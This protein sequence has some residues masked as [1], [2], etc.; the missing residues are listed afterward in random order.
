MEGKIGRKWFEESYRR[1]LVDM[2]IPD[3]D[4]RFL[5]EFDPQRYVEMLTLANVTSAMVYANSH[6]GNCYWPTK[7]GHMHKGLKGRDILGEIIDLCHQRNMDVI[8]Y[9]SLI[10]NNWAYQNHSDWR[11]I[12]IDGREAG[13]NSRYGVC[14]PNSPY[15]DFALAQIEELCKSYEFEGIFFDMTFWPAVC[16]CPH[17]RKRYALEVGGE[18][19][20][21]IDWEDPKWVKFQRKRE[22]W[23]TEFASLATSTV[24]RIRPE[25]TVEHQSSTCPANWQYGVTEELARQSDYLGG[26]F[27]GGSLQ[28][29]FICKL[30]YNLT[31]NM[32]FEFMTSRCP[33][34]RDH[35]TIKSKELLK[36]Q[37]YST[38]TNSGA[39]LFIDAIDPVGT[40]NKSIYEEMGEI[41]RE[42]KR[43]EKYSGG[44]LCQDIG[45][46][47]S[48]ESKID[49]ADN[50]RKVSESSGKMP[51][52][53]AALGAS[54]C[55][56]SCHIPFG[57]I[58]RKN[59][60]DLSSYQ[61]IILA[62]VL[63]MDEEEAEALRKF[64]ASGGS[65]YVSKY[66]SLMTKEGE[67]KEDFLLSD[68]LGISY[69]RETKEEVT[70]ISPEEGGKKLFAGYSAR[71]P[72]AISASQLKVK[73]REKAKALATIALPYTD[74][75]DT[76]RFA[77]IHSN[78]PGIPTDYPSIVLNEYGK[79]KALY[80]A[81]DLESVEQ[82]AH[83][84]IF[85]NL[86]KML[87]SKP[88]SFE[89]DAPES[90]E[91]TLFHQEDKNRYLINLLNFQAELPNIPIEGMKIRIRLDK[92][93]PKRLMKLPGER[94]LAYEVKGGYVHFVVP[95]LETFLMLAL[96]YR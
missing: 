65:L 68:V 56:L 30:F 45:I 51:H 89:A 36:A 54:K 24:K 44:R 39:F 13:E 8:V 96:D 14:C 61:V 29:S 7:T 4:E 79:G 9:Y 2:H 88:F 82:D 76:A 23:L 25:V 53:R 71:Y 49:L 10:F 34:L 95:N 75:R 32:P 92:K 22:E 26:D 74:P 19:P 69:L 6:V 57:V 60:E 48:F 73:A 3:W 93:E 12:T 35:T 31:E 18:P 55:L 81:T 59:L 91:I 5:S 67:K 66:S 77:S 70:Y 20:T 16:Y 28:E 90:V 15:R 94:E 37:A 33:N 58:T 42:T 46:Y 78:P 84:L 27:Y 63:M 64:V 38:L 50:G 43:Y 41:F 40:L 87:S 1:N 72:L 62:N 11:I 80:V 83:R 85:T 52:L 86:I 47:F 17:C 21:M